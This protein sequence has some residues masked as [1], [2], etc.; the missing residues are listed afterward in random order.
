MKFKYQA[1]SKL[2]ELQTGYVDAGSRD[3]ATSIL[4]NHELFIL[5]I[6][7][8]ETLRWYDRISSYFG[9]VRRKDMVAFTRQLAILLEAQLPLNSALRTLYEQ[10]SQPVLKEALGEIVQDIDGGLALSQALEKQS[11]IFSEFF[12][13]LIRSSEATGNLSEAI[14]FLADY[15]EKEGALVS[16]A[17]GAMIYPAIV[18]TLFFGVAIIMV[19]VVFPQL[20]PIFSQSGVELPVFTK[21]LIGSGGFL[22]RY[23]PAL[24]VLIFVFVVV[25]MNY[26]K[27]PEGRAFFD[28]LKIRLPIISRVFVP[29]TITRFTNAGA[30]LIKGGIPVAQALEVVSHTVGNV[31]Y[32]D[33]LHE[34]SDMVRQG[35][36]LSAAIARYP[37]YFPILVSQMIVVGEAT[38]RLDQ[39]FVR[40]TSY[41]TQEADRAINTLVDLIQPMLMIGVGLLV[42][43]LFA[44][45]LIP[46][47][48]LTTKI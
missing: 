45:M 35:E 14:S 29:V 23:W 1:R 46:I 44:S 18:L 5:S 13:S 27:T 33:A 48:S 2:G 12:I 41:Y 37:D 10:T 16:R 9:R 40:L 47:Y 34:I 21:I 3:A 38:G 20:A 25:V 32:E 11:E 39:I 31:L 8:A 28:D 36:P 7:A 26:A 17:I 42:G 19:T 30:L 6:E 43:I 24:I 4:V 15:V 22:G